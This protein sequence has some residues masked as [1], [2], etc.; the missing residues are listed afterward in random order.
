MAGIAVVTDSTSS[1]P[2]GLASSANIRVIPLQVVI[3]GVSRSEGVVSPTEVAAALRSG[4]RVSTSR[5]AAEVFRAAYQELAGEGV[6]GVVSVHLSGTISGTAAAAELAAATVAPPAGIAV[7]VVDTRVIAMASGFAALAGAAAARDGAA[8]DEVVGTVARRAA[9]S[10]T[11]FYVEDLEHLRR[12]GRIGA[13]TAALG[14]ALAVK[15]LLTLRDGTIQPLERVR[16]ASRA[17]ARLEELAR[18]AVSRAQER[19]EDVEVAVHHLDDAAA[20]DRLAGRLADAVG[21]TPVLSEVSAALGVHVGPGTLGV[22]VS[23]V[24]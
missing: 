20:A 8:L 10:E 17:L 22:V 18:A 6:T 3:D 1:L 2:P 11:W 19:G 12:G 5:P 21:V 14:S 15:P 13:A 16:T 4:R 24:L 9:A 23:P 7:R